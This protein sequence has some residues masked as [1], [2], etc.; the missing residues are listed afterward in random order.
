MCLTNSG[1][2]SDH[3]DPHRFDDLFHSIPHRLIHWTWLRLFYCH[4]PSFLGFTGHVTTDKLIMHENISEFCYT[5]VS[6]KKV[7]DEPTTSLLLVQKPPNQLPGCGWPEKYY[8]DVLRCLMET[9]SSIHWWVF[10]THTYTYHAQAFVCPNRESLSSVLR[11]SRLDVIL[12]VPSHPLTSLSRWPHLYVYSDVIK[13][14]H[15]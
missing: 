1:M 3:N 9:G 7:T 5:V 8:N 12:D 10:T 15:Q 11:M 2:R 6:Y 13:I 14:G 4:S